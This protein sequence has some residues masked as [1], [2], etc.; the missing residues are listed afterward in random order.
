MDMSHHI[1]TGHTMTDCP[2]LPRISDL[3]SQ[4]LGVDIVKGLYAAGE[5][6]PSEIT[7]AQHWRIS[8]SAVREGICVLAS[9]GL[10]ERRP[11]AGTIVSE[12]T[13]WNLLDP[14]ILSWMRLSDPDASFV[15]ALLELTYI[16]EPQAAALA[17]KRGS[18]R[19]IDDLRRLVGIM[20]SQNR[21]EEAARRADLQFRTAIVRA[22]G[23]QT[24]IPLLDSIEAAIAWS[25]TYR[26]ALNIDVRGTASSHYLPIVEAIANHD[27]AEAKW[28][29]E[30]LI[31]TT[32]TI[33]SA[34]QRQTF[35][36]TPLVRTA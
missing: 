28:Q 25:H 24:F 8:R 10:V 6:L 31:R 33:V 27:D 9:T 26:A 23:N 30:M 11:K 17:A 16:I 2:H 18:A 15:R 4:Q 14:L 32:M 12:R 13:R 34:Q 7:L 36:D 1:G 22:A 21:T 5:V 19:D 3:I 35:P 29:M 20:R